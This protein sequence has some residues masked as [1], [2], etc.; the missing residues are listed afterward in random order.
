M[1]KNTRT[2][3]GTRTLRSLKQPI[4]MQVKTEDNGVPFVLKLRGR[5]VKVDAV[6]DR[7]RIDDEW[8][9]RYPISRMYYSCAVHR[10]LKITVYRDL[11]TNK[12]Y[13]QKV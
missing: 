1:V 8:W 3:V 5:W 12:W 7:W 11:I 10:G 13:S 4:P 9:R 2:T 6:E